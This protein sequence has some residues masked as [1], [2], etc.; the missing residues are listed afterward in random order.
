[1]LAGSKLASQVTAEGY[2]A[3]LA[4]GTWEDAPRRSRGYARLLAAVRDALPGLE[5]L[6][7]PGVERR[8][9]LAAEIAARTKRSVNTIR[10]HR[11]AIL[12]KLGATTTLQAINAARGASLIV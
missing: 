7:R 12:T 3:I 1:M 6:A 9:A 11:N 4:G 8:G 2:A 10:A 5:L